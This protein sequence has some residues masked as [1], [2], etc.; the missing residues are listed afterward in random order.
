MDAWI[1]VEWRSCGGDARKLPFWGVEG[2]VEW[3]GGLGSKEI[4]VSKY[5]AA[6]NSQEDGSIFAYLIEPAFNR[7]ETL[8]VDGLGQVLLL[9]LV[10]A[11]HFGKV[12]HGFRRRYFGGIVILDAVAGELLGPTEH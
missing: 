9:L 7:I 8:L 2:G 10:C 5:G 12:D 1:K 6:V 4:G 11:S 3:W